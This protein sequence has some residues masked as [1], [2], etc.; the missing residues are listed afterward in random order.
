MSCNPYIPSGS[1]TPACAA[2]P[3]TS[4][5]RTSSWSLP[6]NG[7]GQAIG[8]PSQVFNPNALRWSEDGVYAQDTWTVNPKLTLTYG[9]RYEVYPAPYR[10]RTGA[11]VLLPQ[12]PLSYGNVEVGGINGNPRRAQALEPGGDRS[13]P[14]WA[15]LTA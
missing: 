2:S 13:C 3:V 5:L 10:D 15:S 4:R 6:N 11:S 7:S 8:D 1:T 9:L 14:G 12:L